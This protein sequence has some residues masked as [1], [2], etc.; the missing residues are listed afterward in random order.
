ML[1]HLL[2]LGPFKKSLFHRIFAPSLRPYKMALPG[3]SATDLPRTSLGYR[4]SPLLIK[5]VDAHVCSTL[6]L[7]LVPRPPKEQSAYCSKLAGLFAIVLIVNLIC[8]WTDI[9]SGHIKVGCNGLLALNKTFDTW[10]LEPSD[11]QFDLI[12]AL[13][14]MIS[15]SP[16]TWTTRHVPSHQDDNTSVKLDWWATTLSRSTGCSIC[17]RLLF[18]TLFLTRVFKS[19]SATAN[20]RLTTRLPFSSTSMKRPS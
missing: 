12:S 20:Y 5:I 18:S 9:Q 4:P 14:A 10:P 13:R 8:S 19:G 3:L 11:P 17:I 7:N 2:L 15:S 1:L 6:G 16:V